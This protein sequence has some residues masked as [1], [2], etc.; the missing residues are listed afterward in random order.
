MSNLAVQPNCIKYNLHS[1]FND[2]VQ[3]KHVTLEALLLVRF[4][5]F[6]S[7]YLVMLMI[8]FTKLDS[9]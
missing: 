8:I 7:N 2:F 5:V 1:V 6:S 3:I 4:F 9:T